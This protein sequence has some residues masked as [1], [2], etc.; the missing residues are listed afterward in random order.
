[1]VSYLLPCAPTGLSRIAGWC[2]IGETPWG[3]PWTPV[4]TLQHV[5]DGLRVLLMAVLCAFRRLSRC[6]PV[7]RQ[8]TRNA[9]LDLTTIIPATTCHQRNYV[10]A[11]SRSRRRG[12]T[13]SERLAPR[14][15][16]Q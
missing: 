1:M 16:Q 13:Y 11:Y 2:V 12:D 7:H 10:E 8:L 9:L 3:Q 14:Q 4:L 15:M 5:H 6:R